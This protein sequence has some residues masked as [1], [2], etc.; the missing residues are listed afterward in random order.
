MGVQ[1]TKIATEQ[2]SAPP[3]PGSDPQTRPTVEGTAYPT[4]AQ[5]A[6]LDACPPEYPAAVPYPPDAQGQ[7]PL[8][9][10]AYPD[11]HRTDPETIQTDEVG[12]FPY[13]PPSEPQQTPSEGQAY[14]PDYS[15]VVPYPLP[16]A[17][18]QPPSLPPTYPAQHDPPTERLPPVGATAS[19]A[20]G[21]PPPAP[22][23]SYSAVQ[24]V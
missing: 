7:L 17:Q 10:T 11:Q 21:D 14:P 19:Y 18:G 20:H 16:D 6:S 1:A 4:V 15:T 2:P 9:P 23:V 22:T 13:T 8:Q 12:G 3:Y 5:Q 24:L